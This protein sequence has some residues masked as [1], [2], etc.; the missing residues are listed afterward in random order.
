MR[1]VNHMYLDLHTAAPFASAEH[2]RGLCKF[3]YTFARSNHHGLDTVEHR[4]QR[5]IRQLGRHLSL[6][7]QIIQSSSRVTERFK[8]KVLILNFHIVFSLAQLSTPMFYIFLFLKWSKHTALNRYANIR[9]IRYLQAHF[10]N[11]YKIN[12]SECPMCL[13]V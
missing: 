9:K 11:P 4:F 10:F 2:S 6:G 3:Q 1:H 13:K 12:Y 8:M 5:H 7:I